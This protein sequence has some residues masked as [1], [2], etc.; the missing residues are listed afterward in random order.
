MASAAAAI[1]FLNLLGLLEMREAYRT[2]PSTLPAKL[3]VLVDLTVA[4]TV[5]Y[6]MRQKKNIQLD[7]LNGGKKT[8]DEIITSFN[9]SM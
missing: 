5:G 3:A 1:Q 6:M 9:D 2:L 4:S 8:V 7:Y